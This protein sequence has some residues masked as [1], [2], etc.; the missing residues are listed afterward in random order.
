M[1]QHFYFKFGEGNQHFK[2][3][4]E[5]ES[6]ELSIYFNKEK[7]GW[8]IERFLQDGQFK[9]TE[10]ERAAAENEISVSDI[11]QAATFIKISLPEN[12]ER[13]F[14][15]IF[16]H[17]EIFAF[18]PVGL[19]SDGDLDTSKVVGQQPKQMPTIC[20]RIFKVENVPEFFAALNAH[21]GYNRCTIRHFENPAIH[22]IAEHLLFPKAEKLK[23]AASQ[24]FD[25]LSPVQFETLVF[26]IF[27]HAGAF[28]S[29]FRG[30]T[31]PEIDLSVEF[32][33][34][35]KLSGFT[36]SGKYFLQVKMK[37][38]EVKKLKP[39][40]DGE[41]LIWLGETDLTQKILGKDWLE[42]QIAQSNEVRNWLVRSLDFLEISQ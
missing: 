38:T 9:Q 24:K 27:H 15:W 8:K 36:S 25:F 10:F 23:I 35:P 21:Q 40:N 32:S 30:G 31:R 28:C 14:L 26:L 22:A 11:S 1:N 33:E 34:T 12:R 3:V 4:P 37:N 7:Q 16:K 41:Y 42:R 29:T 6:L 2:S 39:S 18:Q 17:P 19:V 5:G 13:C 20:K